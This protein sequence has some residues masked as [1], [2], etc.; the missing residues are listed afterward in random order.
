MLLAAY[1]ANK[2]WCKQSE[3]KKPKKNPGKWVL[4]WELSARA[5]QWI[6]T[7][8][9]LDDNQ[10]FLH[11][12][13]LNKSNL[14]IGMVKV[15]SSGEPR[16]V[17]LPLLLPHNISVCVWLS[18]AGV[19]DT[20]YST[21]P[22]RALTTFQPTRNSHTYTFTLISQTPRLSL[23]Y[24]IWPQYQPSWPPRY[25]GGPDGWGCGHTVIQ[26]CFLS[27]ALPRERYPPGR[28]WRAGPYL[29][30]SNAASE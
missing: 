27:S 12:R 19:G 8:Q 5:I 10:I 14:S 13:A 3:K 1:L 17:F 16:A 15:A 28:H 24:R 11:P 7:W 23:H 30:G 4:I 2:K 9:G 26:Q 20:S 18:Y 29:Y 25:R 21:E 6:P 22:I